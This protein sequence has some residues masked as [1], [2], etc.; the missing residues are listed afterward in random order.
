M[1]SKEKKPYLEP[2]MDTVLL[3]GSDIVTASSAT[4]GSEEKWDE[5]TP[6]GGWV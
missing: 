5:K 1:K 2:S 4:D 3:I 6:S